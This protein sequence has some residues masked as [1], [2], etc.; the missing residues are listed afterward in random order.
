MT[1]TVKLLPTEKHWRCGGIHWTSSPEPMLIK[2][3]KAHCYSVARRYSPAETK[4]D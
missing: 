3:T 1:V 4:A 2:Y